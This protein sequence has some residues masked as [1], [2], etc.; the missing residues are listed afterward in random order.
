MQPG[1]FWDMTFPEVLLEIKMR[2]PKDDKMMGLT[3]DQDRE[4]AEW[5]ASGYGE[6]T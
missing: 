6:K 1:E 4:L 3:Q 2:A 5:I